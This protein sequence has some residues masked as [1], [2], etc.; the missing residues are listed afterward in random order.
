MFEIFNYVYAWK[1]CKYSYQYYILITV[2]TNKFLMH[3]LFTLSLQTQII[4]EIP[5]MYL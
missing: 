5:Q 4:Y 2:Y 3:M 1:Y